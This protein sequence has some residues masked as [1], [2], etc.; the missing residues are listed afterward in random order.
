L[1]VFGFGNT[2]TLKA[3][4]DIE[5]AGDD[6]DP[7]CC[8]CDYAAVAEPTRQRTMILRS[9]VNKGVP[10][11]SVAN[12]THNTSINVLDPPGDVRILCSLVEELILLTRKHNHIR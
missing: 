8:G 7:P 5:N 1:V 6:D 11:N 9:K 4:V 2:V 10:R 3:I 12:S